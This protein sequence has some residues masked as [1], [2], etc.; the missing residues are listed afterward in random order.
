MEDMIEVRH[1]FCADGKGVFE[2]IDG[3]MVCSNTGH[4]V[5]KELWEWLTPVDLYPLP[6]MDPALER[7]K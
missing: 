2:E 5:P 7:E 3:M 4:A 6:I 1:L